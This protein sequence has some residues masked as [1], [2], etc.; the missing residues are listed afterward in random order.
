LF[1]SNAT[2]TRYALVGGTPFEFEYT[3]AA[4][5]YKSNPVDPPIAPESRLVTQPLHLKSEH[6]VSSLC[7]FQILLVTA[8][9]R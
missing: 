5:L 6:L 8:T 4:G 3:T 2:C 7:F 9:P 1:F